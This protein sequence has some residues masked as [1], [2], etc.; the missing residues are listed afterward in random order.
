MSRGDF[1]KDL[2][3]TVGDVHGL[4]VWRQELKEHHIR[5]GLLAM[6]VAER[7]AVWNPRLAFQAGLSHDIG[8]HLVDSN[9]LLKPG[10]LYG[11]ELA[12]VQ[13]HAVAGADWLRGKGFAEEIVRAARH[14]H[15]RWDGDGYPDG[16]RGTRIP[17]VARV[18]SV[19]DALDAMYRGRH[20]APRLNRGQ[21]L[22][23]LQKGAGT[24][25]D[26][27]VV[28]EVL[29]FLTRGELMGVQNWA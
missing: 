1:I 8:K 17:Y 10:R 14:H 3:A 18:I 26:P 22:K 24:Q 25:F 20:Y 12:E 21:I 7:M 19:C 6:V 5:V 4:G 23:E 11:P 16:L 13:R 2:A 29:K 28:E 9:L 15:E 27:D